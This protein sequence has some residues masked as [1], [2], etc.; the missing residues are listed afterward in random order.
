MNTISPAELLTKLKK[1]PIDYSLGEDHVRSQIELLADMFRPVTGVDVAADTLGGVPAER[2][3]SSQSGPVTMYFHGGGYV[4]GSS[5]SHRHVCSLLASETNG[6]VYAV[7]YRLAPEVPFPGAI[8][9]AIAASL[10]AHSRHK[11]SLALVGDSAGGGLAFGVAAHFASL[12]ETIASCVVGLSPWVNL[13]TSN[14]S[15]LLLRDLD[16]FLSSEIADWHSQRYLQGT[17]QSN[18]LASPIYADL[19]GVP[20]SLIQAG[21]HEVFFGDAVTMHQKLLQSGCKSRLEVGHGL[22]HVWHLYF[23]ILK[24]ARTALERAAIFITENTPKTRKPT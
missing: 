6:I 14:E 23:P 17:D 1:S 9:D 4:T 12:S 22:F 3:T 13:T 8:E 7:D 20:P 21:D 5:K 11:K 24:E 19:D 15:Y 16:P 10:G 2:H 18:P